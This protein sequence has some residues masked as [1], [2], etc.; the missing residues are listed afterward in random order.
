TR[1]ANGRSRLHVE[2]IS[3]P[4]RD[5]LA[6]HGLPDRDGFLRI[7][8]AIGW[9]YMTRLA[10]VV[11]RADKSSPFTDRTT[12]HNLVI[13]RYVAPTAEAAEAV[14][15]TLSFSQ[16]R[17]SNQVPLRAVWQFRESHFGQLQ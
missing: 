11:A 15:A 7:D 17:I 10:A 9:T 3:M 1:Q 4:L 14:L 12:S 6:G 13:D 8:P 16:I 2:K 5:A